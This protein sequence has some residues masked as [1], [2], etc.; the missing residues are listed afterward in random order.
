M[1]I[2]HVRPGAGEEF[3]HV[4]R[5]ALGC[6]VVDAQVI[7][8]LKSCTRGICIDRDAGRAVNTLF[9]SHRLLTF[10]ISA[11]TVYCNISGNCM[12][13]AS[14]C[15][16]VLMGGRYIPCTT[17]TPKPFNPQSI[18]LTLSPRHRPSPPV[19]KEQPPRRSEAASVS[20]GRRVAGQ[21]AGQV[22]P[23]GADGVV[24]VQVVV[25]NCAR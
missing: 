25:K 10:I 15:A 8:A 18:P 4:P 20:R 1:V 13:L 3:R 14:R 9:I 24:S 6:G 7:E 17:L 21:R 22:G 11:H 12:I 19:H 5:P 2:S 16:V 23:G